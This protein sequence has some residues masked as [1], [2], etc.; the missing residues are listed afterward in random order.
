MSL[1]RQYDGDRDKPDP[2]E[3]WITP[4]DVSKRVVTSHRVCIFLFASI[5]FT[6]VYLSFHKTF[7]SVQPTVNTCFSY[8]L[9]YKNSLVHSM[10]HSGIVVLNISQVKT[11]VLLIKGPA[12]MLL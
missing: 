6:L 11:R 9:F 8:N 4:R 2:V 3:I 12:Y 5:I 1:Y 7:Y 10:I